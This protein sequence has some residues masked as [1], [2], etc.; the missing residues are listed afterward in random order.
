MP[1]C[2]YRDELVIIDGIILKGRHIVIPSSLRQQILDQLHTNHMG[3]EKSEL[4]ACESVYW[5]SINTDIESYIK[6]CVTCLELQQM[7]PKEKIIY[8]NIPLRPWEVVSA[9]IFHFNNK[10][11]LCIVDYNSKF[12]V[13]KKLEGF[14]AEC[15]INTVKIIFTKY[16]IP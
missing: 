16:G 14:S 8:H 11:Y 4:L 2:L 15:L 1:Y 13:I 6:H 9:D 5:S 12:S 10:N 7:Q 3:T